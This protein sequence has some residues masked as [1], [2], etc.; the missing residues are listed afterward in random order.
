[1]FRRFRLNSHTA[2]GLL[3][4]SALLTVDEPSH[5]S[6]G[7]SGCAG[8]LTG[9]YLSDPDLN[10]P[11]IDGETCASEGNWFD[12]VAG[13]TAVAPGMG[14]RAKIMEEIAYRP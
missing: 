3:T 11:L 9:L 13:P 8:F 2:H 7:I 14:F 1:M 6:L 4:N 12:K 10:A 5:S